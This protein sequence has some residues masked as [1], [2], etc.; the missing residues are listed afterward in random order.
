MFVSGDTYATVGYSLLYSQPMKTSLKRMVVQSDC[1]S[2]TLPFSPRAAV[3]GTAL[4]LS[5]LEQQD[6]DL[7]EVEVDEVFGFV[8]DVAAEVA[9]H[10]AVPS[11]VVFLVE[12]LLDEGSDVLLDVELLQGVGGAFYGVLLHVVTH[13]GVLDHRLVAP[14]LGHLP[15]GA[16]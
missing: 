6:G 5:Q 1:D 11:G 3:K 9:S 14:L 7:T 2:T 4:S 16:Q 13:V 8:C 15:Q 10:D 12:L